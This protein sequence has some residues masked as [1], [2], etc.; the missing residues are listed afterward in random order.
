MQPRPPRPTGSHQFI[1][2]QTQKSS[3]KI[4]VGGG[5]EKKK[6]KQLIYVEQIGPEFML[7]PKL[8]VVSQYGS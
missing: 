3:Q 6:K 5:R 2:L 4:S 7:H 1:P 8:E